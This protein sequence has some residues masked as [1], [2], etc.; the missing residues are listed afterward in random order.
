VTLGLKPGEIETIPL[1]LGADQSGF[2]EGSI[3]IIGADDKELASRQFYAD[4]FVSKFWARH[5]DQ[6]WRED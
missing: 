1:I 2:F 6:V 5:P 3:R 4:I